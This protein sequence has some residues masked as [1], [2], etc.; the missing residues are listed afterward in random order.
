MCMLVKDVLKDIIDYYKFNTEQGLKEQLLGI[1][2]EIISLTPDFPYYLKGIRGVKIDNISLNHIF[3][4][5]YIDAVYLRERCN[6]DY[7]NKIEYNEE[8]YDSFDEYEVNNLLNT[9]DC[10]YVVISDENPPVLKP[11]ELFNLYF[12]ELVYYDIDMS[13]YKLIFMNYDLNNITMDFYFNLINSNIYGEICNYAIQDF[14]F[15][16]DLDKDVDIFNKLFLS[17]YHNNLSLSVDIEDYLNNFIYIHINMS[18]YHNL[19]YIKQFISKL[20]RQYYVFNK[21]VS[22]IVHLK[23]ND[24]DYHSLT[25]GKINMYSF[26]VISELKNNLGSKVNR[27]YIEIEPE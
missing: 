10:K 18:L 27:V 9:I 21:N 15:S 5:I 23:A 19:D 22:I 2:T 20:K 6:F 11:N 1:E 13:L 26:P 4:T 16:N 17:N 24:K 14:K 8:I 7:P 3:Y 25:V 12:D